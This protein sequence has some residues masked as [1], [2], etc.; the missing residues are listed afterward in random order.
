LTSVQIVT[1]QADVKRIVD[2]CHSEP[3]IGADFHLLRFLVHG[4]E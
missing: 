2:T 3:A 1:K 4:H